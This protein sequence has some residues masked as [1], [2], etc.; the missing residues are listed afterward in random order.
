MMNW[1]ERLMNVVSVEIAFG[2]LKEEVENKK[3]VSGE[4]IKDYFTKISNGNATFK[5]KKNTSDMFTGLV[6][7]E[8]CS[9][10]IK[11]HENG[12]IE[13]L[14]LDLKQ[15]YYEPVV[16]D[17]HISAIEDEDYEKIMNEGDLKDYVANKKNIS[18]SN[19]REIKCNWSKFDNSRRIFE[20]RD[21]A[22]NSYIYSGYSQNI[23][24]ADRKLENAEIFHIANE[25]GM[26]MPGL[27]IL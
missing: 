5:N 7:L 9:I 14:D 23:V 13:S 8:G 25:Y 15:Y 1:N 17:I 22:E 24:V 12:K 20:F 11:A 4:E 3:F 18:D 27:N 10:W 21:E 6:H 2:E 26:F 16:E 19:I